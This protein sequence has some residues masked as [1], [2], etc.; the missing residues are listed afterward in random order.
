MKPKLKTPSI[1]PMSRYKMPVEI[2][3][4]KLKSEAREEMK[5]F[6]EKKLSVS[7]EAKGDRLVFPESAKISR[8]RVRKACRWFVGKG[9]LKKDYRVVSSES[10]IVI[11]QI[12]S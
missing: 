4:S 10:G 9:E 6:L 2:D 1:A 3:I 8:T 12:K 11:R 5:E 7:L